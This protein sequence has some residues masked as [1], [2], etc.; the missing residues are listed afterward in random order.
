M[1][2]SYSKV[3]SHRSIS[4]RVSKFVAS[5]G[6]LGIVESHLLSGK[7]ATGDNG[8]TADLEDYEDIISNCFFALPAPE[9]CEQSSYL[10]FMST[11]SFGDEIDVDSWLAVQV[12]HPQSRKF[13]CVAGAAR[14]RLPYGTFLVVGG[15]SWRRCP[16]P[17][18]GHRAAE[19]QRP[20]LA[21]KDWNT[22]RWLRRNWGSDCKQS[23]AGRKHVRKWT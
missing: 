19:R 15:K 13:A 7:S 22:Y 4:R 2:S 8:N 10:H 14:A 18:S 1:A 3:L 21:D 11:V 20:H 6:I 17:N 12:F 16:A 23:H 9:Q 5:G